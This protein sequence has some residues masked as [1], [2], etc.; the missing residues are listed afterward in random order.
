MADD[1]QLLAKYANEGDV[2]SLSE[3]VAVHTRW[4]MAYLRGALPAE[5][6]AEDA[7]QETWMRVIRFCG[8]YRG[9]SVRGYLARVARSVVTDRFR[10]GGPP[11]VSLDAASDDEDAPS[12][13]LVDGAPSPGESFEL[14]ATSEDVRR[15]VRA[16]PERL[17]DVVLL[18]IEGELTFQEIADEL[19]VPLGTV[20]T[21]MRSA[22]ARLKKT[23]G[24]KR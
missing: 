11:S 23:L 7:F 9:G 17:R 22:T 1:R 21:W 8:S 19:G 13:D 4:L 12:A 14:R 24:E 18:R 6:D 15:A 3:L 2:R 5:S 10:R 16:L 20:L